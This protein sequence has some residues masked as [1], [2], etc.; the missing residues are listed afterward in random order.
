[1]SKWHL[2]GEPYKVQIE[3]LKRSKGHNKFGW[4]LEQGLGK[5]ALQL[6]EWVSRYSRLE[7]V[8][9]IAPN[10]FKQ[11]WKLAPAEWGLDIET[12]NVWPNEPMQRGMWNVINFEAVRTS[13][14]EPIKW[15]LDRNDC[16]LVVDESSAI[17]NFKAK[18]TK[19]V[20]DLCKRAKVVR[21]LNGT[22]MGKD[23]MN[24]YPQLRCLDELEGMNPYA[25]RNTYAIMGG[26]M[27]RQVVG[28]RNEDQL[29]RILNRCSFRAL[30]SEWSDLPPKVF[31][32]VHL[33]MTN[34]QR[35]HYKEM[36]EDLYTV[37]NGH[38][39]TAAMVLSRL[40]KNRQIASGCLLDGDKFVLIEEPKN[41]PKIKAFFDI[42]EG[43]PGKT[44]WVHFYT[45][46]GDVL[47]EEARKRG[48]NPTRVQGGM[49]GE[50]ITA[51][52]L[53]FNDDP[54][55]RVLVAQITA[56]NKGHTLL[57]Q[58]GSDRCSRMVYH[59]LSFNY[60]EK[61]QMNDRIHRSEQDQTCMYYHLSLS[62][63]DEAQ[64]TAHDR[65]ANL[66]SVVVDAVR[67]LGLRG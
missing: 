58:R 49:K 42:H 64:T 23:V 50:D 17:S 56:S 16:L 30:K 29:H 44:V 57:G 41:N 13:G 12:P 62:P 43:G 25:F 53:K 33:E 4:F 20:R 47:F 18:T 19:A 26:F 28:V 9:V 21:L 39:F 48:L 6:E 38:E 40:E 32:P 31:V 54:D 3:A 5:S 15:L 55:C 35:K 60:I 67:A 24:L 27:G 63:I 10:S 8:V 45:K 14:Y 1:M 37:V 52:K 66:V 36:L 46:M 61:E 2:K 22:P 34:K 59:D 7:T 65:K 51:Q 11:D